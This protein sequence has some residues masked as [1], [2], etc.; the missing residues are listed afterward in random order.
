[1][2]PLEA[3]FQRLRN[4]IQASTPLFSAGGLIA[5]EQ[6]EFIKV[7][8]RKGA[9]ELPI[10]T[11]S[12][13]WKCMRQAG[14]Q[15]VNGR[16]VLFPE[17]KFGRA[18]M[19]MTHGPQYISGLTEPI[20]LRRAMRPCQLE[21][22]EQRGEHPDGDSPCILCHRFHLERYTIFMRNY[23][24]RGFSGERPAFQLDQAPTNIAQMWCNQFDVPD[25]YMMEH[26]QSPQPNEV[27]VS[28]IAQCKFS[29]LR[30]FKNE[31]G[32]WQIDH[33]RMLWRSR[34]LLQP[35]MGESLQSFRR[36]ASR[37]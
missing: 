25:G 22:L 17:C 18:C 21:A 26:V 23:T 14:L 20:I 1:V 19:G 31:Q 36:G 3:E 10:Y 5:T 37:P 29:P 9:L 24:A 30:A 6:N 7:N 32:I 4:N 12:H 28:P 15:T 34:P 27:I 33:S 16:T 13:E 35:G 8:L 2:V 11:A